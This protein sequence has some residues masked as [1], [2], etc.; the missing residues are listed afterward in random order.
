MDD[1]ERKNQL[2]ELV[3][4]A[5]D[6]MGVAVT[7]IDKKGTLLYYNQHSAKILELLIIFLPKTSTKK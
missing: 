7:I 2:R 6:C 4:L 1:I 5:V 3:N